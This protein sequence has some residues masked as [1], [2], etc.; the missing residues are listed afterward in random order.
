[1]FH[2]YFIWL[3]LFTHFSHALHMIFTHI[4]LVVVGADRAP[5]GKDDEATAWLISFLNVGQQI[6][7]EKENFII[8]GANCGESHISM[9]RFA[10]KA[11]CRYI[12]H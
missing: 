10:K 3:V 12:S 9:I 5:F 1:M 7:S 4:P 6:T 2:I 8:A 11:C